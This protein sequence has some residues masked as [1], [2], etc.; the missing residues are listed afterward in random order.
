MGNLEIDGKEV[1]LCFD[2]ICDQVLR[3]C[4]LP[5]EFSVSSVFTTKNLAA[6][7]WQEPDIVISR[8]EEKRS[9]QAG[10]F[11][12]EIRGLVFSVSVGR[13]KIQVLSISPA[14]GDITFAMQKG[15]RI[16]G[17]GQGFI[18]CY[19]RRGAK[20]NLALYGQI[21]GLL[22]NYS[23]VTPVAYVIGDG[24]ALYFHQ[25]WGGWMDLTGD[26]GTYSKD[27]R[28][29]GDMFLVNVQEP[30]DAAKKYYQIVGLPPLPPRYALGYQ[31]SYRTLSFE[32]DYPLKTARYM[33]EHDLPCDL[34]IYLGTG[35]CDGGW[36]TNNGK[37][38][39]NSRVFPNPEKTMRELH[40][41]HYKIALHTIFT[42]RSLHG[43]LGDDEDVSPLEYDHVENYWQKHREVFSRAHNEAW[44]PDGD[45]RMD[46][47][48][49][50]TRL[51]MYYE[52]SLELLPNVRPFHLDHDCPV[53]F[54]RWGGVSWSGDV[55]SEWETLKNH[56]PL[57]LSVSLSC[58]PYYSSDTGGFYCTEEYSGELYLRW[59]E[60]NTFTPF[61]R[62][63]GRQAYLHNPW[64]W[65]Q[66][67]KTDEMPNEINHQF[68]DA[69]PLESSLG[70]E[71]VEPIC[72]KYIHERYKLL[73]YIYTLAWEASEAGLPMMR[74]LWTVYPG[75]REAVDVD[76]EYMFGANLL[77]TPVTAQGAKN[78]KVYFPG[79]GKWYDY[80]TGKEY[81][82]GTTAHVS[83]ELDTIPVFVTAGGI[84]VKGP[85]IQYVDTEAKKDFDEI[86]VEIY[87]GADGKYTLYEDDGI[88]L[89]YKKGQ[90]T[91]TEIRWDDQT[92]KINLRGCSSMRGRKNRELKVIL[93]PE[94]ETRDI[95]VTYE[96]IK[97]A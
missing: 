64:G 18:P 70:D 38:V 23:T 87:R 63:H 40:D 7:E 5:R 62:S 72:R 74:P 6:R 49:L 12:V 81:E 60:Y 58:T 24:W 80:W 25:P 88:S 86:T 2:A 31:Q 51:R 79:K 65:S 61:L 57:G 69:L 9:V 53:G 21:P 94:G 32:K 43:E 89:D 4:I 34:L 36:N 54:T 41:L 1:K 30:L 95:S 67:K 68:R 71:L 11:T 85:V 10:P 47:L 20:Y 46:T 14:T 28:E 3:I 96:A 48:S 27:D 91:K 45:E 42:P 33:R 17:L 93:Y 66:V 52:G 44:W 82:G 26:V 73:P 90:Y 76:N 83:A 39:W 50:I 22:E 75:D 35:F 13:K 77:V 16:Y 78:W 84:V 92:G 97:E 59:F 8:S 29:Y 15:E 19:N 37:F 56:I 55:M